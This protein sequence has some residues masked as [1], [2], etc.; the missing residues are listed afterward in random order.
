MS[1]LQALTER[2][3]AFRDARDWKQFHN[4]KDLAIALSVEA[5]EVL[6]LFRFKEPSE[7][8]LEKLPDE[9][10]DVFYFVL[11]LAHEAGVDLSS[12]LTAKMGRN[13]EKY[14]VALSRGSN[15][16]YDELFEGLSNSHE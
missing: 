10:A 1:E 2:I 7:A 13:E 6:E 16:K 3:L 15:L 11:L 8:R 4:P 12:A 5:A 14:P 9:L